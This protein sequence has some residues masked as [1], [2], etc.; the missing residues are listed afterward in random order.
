MALLEVADATRCVEILRARGVRV[1]VVDSTSRYESCRDF[2]RMLDVFIDP[3][4]AS[5]KL[6]SFVRELKREA[7]QRIRPLSPLPEWRSPHKPIFAH[8]C[9]NVPKPSHAAARRDSRRRRRTRWLAEL[10]A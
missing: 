10:R 2:D 1:V 6:R 9:P 4:A 3:G 5:L 7:R 8:S